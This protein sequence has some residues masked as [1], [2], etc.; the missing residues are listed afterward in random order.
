MLHRES[1]PAANQDD[2][3]FMLLSLTNSV[4]G[5]GRRRR[6]E[7]LRNPTLHLFLFLLNCCDGR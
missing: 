7:L 3:G 4:S 2:L 1:F 5:I 6:R